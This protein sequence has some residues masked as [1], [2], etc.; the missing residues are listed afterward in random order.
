MV[1]SNKDTKKCHGK[2]NR[3]NRLNRWKQ[4]NSLDLHRIPP[5]RFQDPAALNA[6][7][8]CSEKSPYGARSAVFL[9]GRIQLKRGPCNM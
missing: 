8:R 7:W 4:L 3:L 6:A 2:M 9:L 1:L 5:C